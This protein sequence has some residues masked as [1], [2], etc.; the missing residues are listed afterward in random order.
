M[1]LL[2]INSF[3]NNSQGGILS[4]ESALGVITPSEVVHDSLCSLSVNLPIN[5]HFS[6]TYFNELL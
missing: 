6:I 5:Y 3:K 2:N 1:F 4:F